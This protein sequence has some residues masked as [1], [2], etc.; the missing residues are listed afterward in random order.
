MNILYSA[1]DKKNR[2]VKLY[3]FRTEGEIFLSDHERHKG[4]TNEI[5]QRFSYSPENVEAFIIFKLVSTPSR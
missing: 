3:T 5:L 2:N 4:R 1:I